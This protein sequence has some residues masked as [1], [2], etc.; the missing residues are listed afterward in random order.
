MSSAEITAARAP[1]RR[2]LS[3]LLRHLQRGTLGERIGKALG[4]L[5]AHVRVRWYGTDDPALAAKAL[6]RWAQIFADR[7]GPQGWILSL[8]EGSAFH[9]RLDRELARRGLRFRSLDLGQTLALPAAEAGQLAGI[10][11]GQSDARSLT[12]TVSALAAHPTLSG[13]AFEY[14]A[15]L[16]AEK[17]QFARQDEYART[18]FVAPCLQDSPG[19]YAIYQESL[20]L[21]EQKCGLRDFLDLY[22][23]LRHVVENRVPGD[24]AEF[25][26]Y[27]GHSGWLIARTLQ[28]LGSDKRVFLFDMFEQFPP[29]PYGM[30]HYWNRSH[31]VD[32]DEVRRK[33]AGFAQVQLVKGDFT[34]TLESCGL[35]TIALAYVDCDSY[36]AT[37]YLIDRLWRQHLPTGGALVCEDYGHPALLGNRAAV[38]EELDHRSGAYKFFSQFSGLHVTLKLA[39]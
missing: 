9:R 25:G 1:R 7:A 5:P 27:R 3:K 19:P 23:V 17:V 37:R 39:S 12:A 16:D 36:R 24:I 4:R 30:D 29:E 2:Y 8:G 18:W 35:G 34:Q 31:F 22:Q 14:A 10:V 11:A 6:A 38:H 26:S 20:R 13:V 28:A 33:L 15:G 32:F 21:F